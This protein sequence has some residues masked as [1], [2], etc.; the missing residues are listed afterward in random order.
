MTQ[1]KNFDSLIERLD[2]SWQEFFKIE[3]EKN[4][5]HQLE[6]FVLSEYQENTIYPLF[7]S[8]FY[9]LQLTSL[10]QLKV[11]LIGQDPYHNDG[12][13][14]GLSFSVPHQQPLPPSLKNIFKELYDDLGIENTNGDLTSWA[15]QGIMLLNSILTVRAHQPNSHHQIGWEIFTQNL[16]EFILKFKN[17]NLQKLVFIVWGSQSLKVIKNLNL[18][19]HLIVQSAHPSPLS[20]YRGFWGSKPFSKTNQFLK[21][22]NYQLIDWKIKT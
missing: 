13:A 8:L 17:D 12:Q 2:A 10:S 1:S 18:T 16:I 20:C 21:E 11:I 14:M 15:Q 9:A 3:K 5:Y 22:K 6:N 7:D 4:Y 19:G